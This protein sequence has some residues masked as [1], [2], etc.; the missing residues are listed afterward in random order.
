MGADLKKYIEEYLNQT[1][2]HLIDLVVRGEKNT[3]VLEIYLDRKEPAGL[4]DYALINKELWRRIENN[5]FARGLSKI[6]VSSPGVDK[7]FKY[8]WQ[9]NRHTGRKLEIKLNDG[10]I[11]EGILEEVIEDNEPMIVLGIINET[12]KKDQ[13]KETKK[14]CFNN[15]KESK[16][17]LSF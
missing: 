3:K 13:Q 14:I 17:I 2:F 7:S 8:I 15:I 4:S 11:I 1:E 6:I 16:V 5:N 12:K 10:D 9:L